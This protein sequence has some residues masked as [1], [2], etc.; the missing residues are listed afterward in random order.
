[1]AA[2]LCYH[3]FMKLKE[4]LGKQTI[5]A[6]N[7]DDFIIY[8]GVI[9]AVEELNQPVIV[10]ISSGEMN[11]WGLERFVAVARSEKLPVF[12]NFDHCRDFTVAKQVIDLGFDMIH[13]DGS[14]LSWEENLRL[15]KDIVSLAHKKEI[16]VEGEPEQENTSV[17]KVE[18]MIKET[19]LDLVAV[20]VGNRH[21]LEPK[22]RERLDLNHLEKIKKVADGKRL[23]LHGGSGV[24]ETDL[25]K[26]I[27]KGMISKININSK[28]RLVYRKVLEE[29]VKS[30]RGEKVYQL[31]EPVVLAIKE[32]VKR[33][34]M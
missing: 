6:F 9:S 33:C 10:Q 8:R 30:Y 16:L 4:L 27:S 5:F 28:L 25:R 32:E 34:L 20:F 2:L 31:M 23:T 13:F 15:T 3:L 29:Q 22:K 17:E 12:L 11:F 14:A 21:G 19:K 24:D 7:C 18:E 1:M 26:A